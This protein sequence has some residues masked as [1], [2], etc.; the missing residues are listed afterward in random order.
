M[1]TCEDLGFPLAAEKLEGLPTILTVLGVVT[2]TAVM[3]INYHN[4]MMSICC[5]TFFTAV[6]S[7]CLHKK[8][9]TRKSTYLSPKDI[10]TDNKANPY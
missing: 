9:T 6:N 10:A 3:K 2:D 1:R 4:I 7:L 8:L 5:I